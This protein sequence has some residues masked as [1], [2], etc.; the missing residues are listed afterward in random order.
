MFHVFADNRAGMSIWRGKRLVYFGETP[1]LKGHVF[2]G[3][4]PNVFTTPRKGVEKDLTSALLESAIGDAIVALEN[5]SISLLCEAIAAVY[6][7]QLMLGAEP[8]ENI[9]EAAK[10]YADNFAL[11]VFMKPESVPAHGQKC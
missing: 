5:S 7:T 2:L 6:M 9:D 11:Y 4:P 10:A 3:K 8:L 1:W